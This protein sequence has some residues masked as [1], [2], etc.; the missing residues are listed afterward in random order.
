MQLAK[1]AWHC[2]ICQHALAAQ[3]Y[4]AQQKF[5]HKLPMHA[6]LPCSMMCSTWVQSKHCA[7]PE[8]GCAIAACNVSLLLSST[9]NHSLSILSSVTFKHEPTLPV[10][11]SMMCIACD[12]NANIVLMHTRM[13]EATYGVVWPSARLLHNAAQ[14]AAQGQT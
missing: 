1:G 5:T 4:S 2:Q 8:A 9:C 7:M 14:E 13:C 10:H 11:R 6:Q 3:R 12:L